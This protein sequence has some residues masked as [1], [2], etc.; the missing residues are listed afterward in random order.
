MAKAEANINKIV[1]R[2]DMGTMVFKL[3]G[4]KWF[5]FKIHLAGVFIKLAALAAK[6]GFRIEYVEEEN[7]N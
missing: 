2:G 6:T 7:D 4:V 5:N 1:S 3:R